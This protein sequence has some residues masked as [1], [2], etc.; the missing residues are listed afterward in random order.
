MA[1]PIDAYV[2]GLG[3]ALRGPRRLRRD[4]VAEARDG[5]VDAAEAYEEAGLARPEAERRAVADFGDV[6]EIAPG[7]QAELTVA[8]GRRTVLMLIAVVAAQPLLWRGW[9][10]WFKSY[11]EAAGGPAYRLLN[12][13]MP[14]IGGGTILAAILAALTLGL[15]S[16]YVPRERYGTLIRAVGSGVLLTCGTFAGLGIAMCALSPAWTLGGS[17][18]WVTPF[19]LLPL[20]VVAGAAQRCRALA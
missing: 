3:R 6:A 2:A 5:L 7:Y 8:Q 10:P 15:G 13:A 17:L 11:P 19:L 12:E 9:W 18:L 20:A 16:R 1:N 4:L 14:W